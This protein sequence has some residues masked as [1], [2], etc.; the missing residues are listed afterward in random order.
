MF[1][2]TP[3]L[4]SMLLAMPKKS[5]SIFGSYPLHGYRTYFTRQRTKAANKLGNP[6]LLQIA[7]HTFRHWKTTME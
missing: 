3:K 6:R 2:I 4:F 5:N 1:K 7:F